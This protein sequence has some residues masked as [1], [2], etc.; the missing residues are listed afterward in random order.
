MKTVLLVF[1]TRPEAIKICPLVLALRRRSAL[2]T[3][4]CVTGQHREMLAGALKAF[5]VR[6]DYDLALMR[7]G[8]TPG[9]LTAAILSVLPDVFSRERPDA[10]LVHGDTTTAFAAALCAF[11][12]H[13]PV[14]HVEAGLRSGDLCAPFPEEFDR[15]AVDLLSRWCFA[16]TAAAAD[17]LRREGVDPARIFLTGNTI[18]DAMAIT[19]PRA[20]QLLSP[21]WPEGTAR[22]LF[23][24]HRRENFG[25]ALR[26][27]LR[28]LRRLLEED[29]AAAVFPVHDNPTVRAAVREELADCPRLRL[30]GPL[31]VVTFHTLEAQCRFCLT[32]S[33]G[34]QEECTA[35]G[36]PVLLMRSVTERPEA[37][38]AGV[39]RLVGTEE[40]AIVCAGREL[41]RDDA[42]LV[43]MSRA[44]RVF[45]D[46]HASERIADMLEFGR[47][48]PFVLA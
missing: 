32:D 29:G 40:D 33:G 13:L 48:E 10:V 9:E 23:T 4:V 12:A 28:A 2:R 27:M 36:K 25:P 41:L 21:L 31:D 24:A 22:L 42:L 5:G 45:G 1:G 30:T 34:V 37:V 43:R 8:Q 17:N 18:I 20:A 14:G 35:L 19:A 15:R 26:G 7:P 47:C 44:S 38:D 6:P 46:G 3:V 39:M 16:P 11:Y